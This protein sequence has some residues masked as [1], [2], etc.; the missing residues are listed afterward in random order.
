MRPQ[1]TVPLW[2][3]NN[4][5]RFQPPGSGVFTDHLIRS[6]DSLGVGISPDAQGETVNQYHDRS[7]VQLLIGSTTCNEGAEMN[8][9]IP[10][11]FRPNPRKAAGD[12]RYLSAGT[13]RKTQASTS[14]IVSP[15]GVSSCGPC[16][17]SCN[18]IIHPNRSNQHMIGSK[19]AP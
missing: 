5:R 3:P 8:P 16:N 2:R 1:G 4:T 14:T 10:S 15:T 13:P 7:L 17:V 19:T 18:V 12:H 6:R 11:R 9:Y